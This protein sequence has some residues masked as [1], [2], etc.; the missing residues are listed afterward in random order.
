M[1]LFVRNRCCELGRPGDG[2]PL[3]PRSA[4]FGVSAVLDSNNLAFGEGLPGVAAQWNAGE[5]EELL[6]LVAILNLHARRR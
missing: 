2:L 1:R 6:I 4:R 3:A 5:Q